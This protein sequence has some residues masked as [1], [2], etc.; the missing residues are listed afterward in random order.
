[1]IIKEVFGLR[2]FLLRGLEKVRSIW[3]FTCGVHNLMKLF[4]AGFRLKLA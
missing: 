1:G 2:Q 4:R 3:R